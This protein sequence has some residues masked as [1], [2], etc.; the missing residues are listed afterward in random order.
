MAACGSM[1]IWLMKTE[2]RGSNSRADEREPFTLKPS[3]NTSGIFAVTLPEE[4]VACFGDQSVLQRRQRGGKLGYFSC[5]SKE[6]LKNIVQDALDDALAGKEVSRTRVIRY[7]FSSSVSYAK[8]MNNKLSHP[9]T[10]PC[11]AMEECFGD[12]AEYQWDMGDRQSESQVHFH[13]VVEDRIDYRTGNG[14]EYTEYEKVENED[15]HC[16]N[17]AVAL[18]GSTL[19]PVLM[20]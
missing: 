8:R 4:L 9:L 12:R 1:I 17:T 16:P 15:M 19:L 2:A 14:S 10:I 18:R 3:V 20:P 11:M 5:D 7:V 6:G 13:A